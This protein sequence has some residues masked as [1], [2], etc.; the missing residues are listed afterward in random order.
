M[1]RNVVFDI[2]RF[3]DSYGSAYKVPRCQIPH[4]P[5]PLPLPRPR[6]EPSDGFSFETP[7]RF[8]RCLRAGG[9]DETLAVVL[10]QADG[11]GG[12]VNI[13]GNRWIGLAF[14]SLQRAWLLSGPPLQRHHNS[15]GP[16]HLHGAICCCRYCGEYNR[17]GLF[18]G[19]G[20]Y[21][22]TAWLRS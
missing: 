9:L 11:K 17:E 16:S 4:F 18:H 10:G 14:G 13:A 20:A 8:T 12:F 22:S 3:Q 6:C 1:G 7:N 19:Q 15:C 21:D 2:G 5:L